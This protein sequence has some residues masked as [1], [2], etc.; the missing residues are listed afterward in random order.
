MRDDGDDFVAIDNLAVLGDK[1]TTVAIAIVSDAEIEMV[2]CDEILERFEMSGAT[3][4][5]DGLVVTCIG[6]DESDFGAEIFENGLIDDGSSAVCAI[7]TDVE[8]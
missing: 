7:H 4:M 3:I 8:I 2:F 1:E 5:I 6:I